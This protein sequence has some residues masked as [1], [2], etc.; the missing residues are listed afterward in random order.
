MQQSSF[1][2]VASGP[3]DKDRIPNNFST[4]D[5]A[6]HKEV[7]ALGPHYFLINIK[8]FGPVADR[9]IQ[10][11]VHV[12][13]DHLTDSEYDLGQLLKLYRLQVEFGETNILTERL[14]LGT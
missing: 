14:L 7:R 8:R 13:S 2:T 1:H 6:K 12:L 10:K 3:W 4:T 5:P 9:T 11:L